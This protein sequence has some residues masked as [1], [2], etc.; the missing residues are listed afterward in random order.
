MGI[1]EKVPHNARIELLLDSTIQPL[2]YTRVSTPS[3][4]GTCSCMFF[5]ALFT[6]AGEQ[7]QLVVHQPMDNENVVH[8]NKEILFSHKEK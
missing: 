6:I 1:T 2:T 5:D 4:R 7:D 8:I 3:G